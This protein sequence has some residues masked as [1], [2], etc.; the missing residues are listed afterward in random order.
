M[1]LLEKAWDKVALIWKR[2]QR[3]KDEK[4]IE[5]WLTEHTQN[6]PGK[7][8]RSLLEISNG[9]RI[10]E[11]RVKS[12]CLHNKMIFL[13]HEQPGYYSVWCQEEQRAY[14]KRRLLSV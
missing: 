6:E 3:E 12:A 1:S 13:C 7:M 4:M 11:E 5:G 9:L 2:Y 8:H 14:E 10:S